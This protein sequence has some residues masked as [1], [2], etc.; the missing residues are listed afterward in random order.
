MQKRLVSA[1]LL[2]SFLL[3]KTCLAQYGTVVFLFEKQAS[4]NIWLSVNE[5]PILKQFSAKQFVLSNLQQEIIAVELGTEGNSVPFFKGLL[6]LRLG[7]T[8]TYSIN[9]K[10]KT[11]TKITPTKSI[12]IQKLKTFSDDLTFEESDDG[13]FGYDDS[14]E[15]NLEFTDAITELNA[16]KKE[17]RKDRRN[18][19]YQKTEKPKTEAC[20]TQLNNDELKDLKSQLRT[21]VGFSGQMRII[22]ESL[23]SRCFFVDQLQEIFKILEEDNAKLSLIKKHKNQILDPKNVP[24]LASEFLLESS[25][26][27]LNKMFE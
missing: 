1:L 13:S 11:A 18:T 24:S 21:M 23:L 19:L 16:S 6:Y 22:S 26:E 17:L 14:L 27:E 9:S 3:V 15:D 5:K 8:S 20:T 7:D 4:K 10:L 2:L 25:I 12:K